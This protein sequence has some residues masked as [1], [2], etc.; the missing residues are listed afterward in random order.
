[1]IQLDHAAI[2]IIDYSDI[3]DS[4][5]SSNK[6]LFQATNLLAITRPKDSVQHGYLRPYQYN[7]Q[8]RLYP[9]T[10]DLYFV[11]T[12]GLNDVGMG[13]I[14]F[15]AGEIGQKIVLKSGLLPKYQTE[16]WIELKS[17]PKPVI[18]K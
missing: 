17:G 5:L 11:S 4:D 1:Y 2:G 3:S 16:R 9:F 8:D 12:S 13:F 15:V 18:V 7:L 6:Q 14:A 10:R